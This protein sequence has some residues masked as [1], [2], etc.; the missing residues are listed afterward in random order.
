MG[1]LLAKCSKFYVILQVTVIFSSK[2]QYILCNIASKMGYLLAKCFKFYG[3][4]QVIMGYL[5]EKFSRFDIILQV[6]GD[7]Y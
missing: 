3:I 5:L 6:K 2:M 1:N 4:L 7:I